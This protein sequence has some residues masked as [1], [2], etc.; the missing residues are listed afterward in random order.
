MDKQTYTP[1]KTYSRED[2]LMRVRETKPLRWRTTFLPAS[3]EYQALEIN[4]YEKPGLRVRFCSWVTG[5][6]CVRINQEDDG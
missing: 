6:R 1:P 2:L 4:T 3:D 5:G